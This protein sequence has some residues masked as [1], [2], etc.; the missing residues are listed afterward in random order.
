MDGAT[1]LKVKIE[2]ATDLCFTNVPSVTNRNQLQLAL[3]AH[4]Q[5]LEFLTTEGQ[6][7][8]QDMA[9][10]GLMILVK[11]LPLATEI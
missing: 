9:I 3:N 1:A 10:R 6:G 5:S 2:Q 11:H 4:L 8:G 7:L